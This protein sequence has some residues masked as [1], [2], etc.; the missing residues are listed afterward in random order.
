[1]VSA[2]AHP[3]RTWDVSIAAPRSATRPRTRSSSA[4]L[5]SPSTDPTEAADSP[6][7]LSRSTRPPPPDRTPRFGPLILSPLPLPA[8]LPPPPPLTLLSRRYVAPSLPPP[9]SILLLAPPTTPPARGG[10]G[11]IGPAAA[12]EGPRFLSALYGLA[13]TVDSSA[14]VVARLPLRLRG[15]A[16]A[17]D[18]GV[19]VGV[20]VGAGAG[21]ARRE[22]LR[23]EGGSRPLPSVPRPSLPLPLPLP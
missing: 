22:Y 19:A 21:V 11:S 17:V 1:M 8:P 23:R 20:S 9:L 15:A 3:H 18:V 4:P 14:E 16:E 2:H 13:E 6:R 5:N 10:G 7:P 12:A